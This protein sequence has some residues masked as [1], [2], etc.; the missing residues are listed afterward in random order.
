MGLLGR[1]VLTGW[2]LGA[3]AIVITVARSLHERLGQQTLAWGLAFA[4]LVALGR[5]T[6]A[7]VTPI[8]R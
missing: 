3:F 2:L 8:L 4:L 5:G 6:E 1:A 7:L